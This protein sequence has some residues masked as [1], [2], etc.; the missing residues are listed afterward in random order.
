MSK[1]V[2]ATGQREDPSPLVINTHMHLSLNT[3]ALGVSF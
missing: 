1:S 2:S 3:R